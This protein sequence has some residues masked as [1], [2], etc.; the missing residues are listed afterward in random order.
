MKY[1][2]DN[3][4]YEVI[5]V[6]K[7]NKNTYIRVKEDCKIYVTTSFFTSQNYI[8]KL[9][10]NNYEQVKKMIDRCKEKEAK[11][12]LFYYLGDI[13]DIIIVP[14]LKGIE[15]DHHKIFVKDVAYLN[16][17]LKR[18]MQVVFKERLDYHYQRFEE[19][20]PYPNLKIRKM[21]SRWGVCNRKNKNVTLNSELIK[22]SYEEIDYVIIHELSHFVH[23]DH[24]SLFWQ[25]VGKY[26]PNYKIIRKSLKEG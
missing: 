10:D 22:Y 26:C 14:T 25:T 1:E 12:S 4:E 2:V 3:E 17:W 19:P 13:Y 6:K 23:F 24:S 5:I 20:I 11:N 9:L 18:Q 16:K 8:R 15:I 21:T 7:N